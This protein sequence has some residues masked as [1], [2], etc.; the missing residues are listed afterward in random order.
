MHGWYMYTRKMPS[1]GD[2]DLLQAGQPYIYLPATGFRSPYNSDGGNSYD[3]SVRNND[4]EGSYWTAGSY[5]YNSSLYRGYGLWFKYAGEQD[6]NIWPA[7]NDYH[8]ER[9]VARSVRPVKE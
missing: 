8:S 7:A 2:T 5:I 1:A 9:A 6:K 3:V 4:T